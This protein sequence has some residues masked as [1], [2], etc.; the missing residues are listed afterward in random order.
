MTERIDIEVTNLV[1]TYGS[2]AKLRRAVDDIS[3]Q[4]RQGELF[5]ILGPNGAGKTTTIKVMLTTLLPTSGRVRVL[6]YDVERDTKQVRRHIG[7]VLGGDKGFYDRLSARQNMTYFADLYEV[8]SRI[9]R[10]RIG[11]LLELVGLGDRSADK[12]ETFSR[13]MKQRLHIARS[14]IHDP[15]VLFLDEPTSGIDPVGA[16]QL[17]ELTGDLTARGKTVVLTTHDMRE[18]EALCERLIVV[19]RGSIVAEGK[20]ASVKHRA[21]VFRVTE[22]ELMGVEP[23]ALASLEEIDGITHVH[24]QALGTHQVV[25]IQSRADTDCMPAVMQRLGPVQ[26]NRIETREPTLEDAYVALIAPG[27]ASR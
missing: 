12:V 13:G 15:Q 2:G 27:V 5:G 3:F 9:Q 24:V 19:S 4:V 10:T 8:P 20:P 26:F 21:G 14:L 7:Y 17:R 25:Q 6:G 22:V 23:R 18:A 1:R 16:R 11:E